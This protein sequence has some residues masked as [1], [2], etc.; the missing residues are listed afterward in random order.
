MNKQSDKEHLPV[1][2]VGP[3]YGI[4]IILLTVVGIVMSMRG[5]L[6]SGMLYNPI[7][8]IPLIALGALFITGGFIVW[9][10]AALGKS[11]I[12]GYIT[13][14]T[15]CTTGIYGVVRNPCYSGI[16]MMC[17]GSLLI[18]HNLWLFILP[19]IFWISMT[20]LLINSE[21]K[22]LKMLYGQEY[23]AYCKKVNRCIPWFPRK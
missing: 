8:V 7:F 12:D 2:G 9:K 20:I 11:N 14:N 22:W 3:F 5:L 23:I 1:Y 16:A 4:G 15:L 19:F 18:A 17:T 6:D 10:S 13:S 21:E